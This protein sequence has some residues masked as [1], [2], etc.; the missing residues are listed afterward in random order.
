M[1]F[2][3]RTRA[4]KKVVVFGLGFLGDMVHISP[5]LWKIRQAYPKSEL[6]VGVAAHVASFL[7]CMP[8]IDR[9]WGYSRFPKH[10]SFKENLDFVTRLRR[11]RFDVLINLNGSD[12]SSWLTF[13]SGARERLGRMP[14]GGGPPFWRQ[15]FTEVV[16][17]P[18]TAGPIY[19]QNC[20]CLEKAG[21]PAASPEFHVDIQPAHLQAANISPADAETYFHLSPFTT[22]DRKE[23]PPEQLVE[24]IAVLQARWPE[25]KLAISCAPTERERGK[26][27]SMLA[28]LPDKPW[29]V[30]AGE[31][32]LTQVA[33]VIQ[34]SALHFCGD[35]GTLHLAL[36]AGART[37]SWFWPNPGRAAWIPVG[38]RHR[39]IVGSTESGA[40][41]LRGIEVNELVSAAQAV[42]ETIDSKAALITTPR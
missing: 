36:L 31:L 16:Q 30:F 21:F 26:M 40:R 27:K 7:E 29:R 5:A 10:A 22:D 19:V 24:L 41:Y 42:L 34:R 14:E 2:L 38:D 8:W 15:M 28:R 1:T 13:F 4:A 11:E 35:T 23:L 33:A 9:V 3:E 25:K 32:N 17:E 12:R 20:R 37:V 6:H 18:F 39:T